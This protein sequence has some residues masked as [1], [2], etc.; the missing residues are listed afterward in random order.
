MK[1][2]ALPISLLAFLSLTATAQIDR[3]HAPAPGPAPEINIGTPAT[4]TLANGL[5]VFVV[6]NHKIPE[7]TAS[8]V[9]KTDPVLE[10][11]RT[12]YVNM[13]GA[14]MRRG[15][16]TKTKAQLDEEIDFLGGNVSTSSKGAS[17]SGLTKN[18]DK[19]FG[20]LADI[21]LHP[22]FPGSE[23]EKIRKQTLSGLEADKDDPG[24][25]SSNVAAVLNYGKDHPYGEVETEQTVKNI[26]LAD[27]KSYYDNYWKPN[28]GYLVLVG[29]IN[30]TAAERLVKKYFEGWQ[31]GEVPAHTYPVPQ[32]PAQT[33]VALVDRPAAVQSNVEITNPVVLKPGNPENIPAQL[34]NDVLGGGSDSYL[35][36]D[37]RE[38]HAY[39][40]GAYSGISNDPVVG[41]FDASAA[42]RNAVTDSAV[43]R[44]LYQLNNIRDNKVDPDV[45]E[46][47]KNSMSGS[48]ARSLES[49]GKI[50]QFALN[51][52][53]YNMPPDYY[54]DYLKNL[55]AVTAEDV[56]RAAR[57]FVTPEHTNIVIVGNAKEIAPGLAKFGEIKYFDNY[58][59]PVKAPE[60]KALP[61]GVT[62]TE[63]ISNYIKAIGG[64]EQLKAVKD[65]SMQATATIQG[66][67]VSFIQKVKYPDRY[68]KE[69]S[70]PKLNMIAMKQE[71]KGDSV[72]MQS[73]GQAV[74]IDEKTKKSI[75]E[76]MDLFPELK[77]NDP[78]YKMELT[79]IESVSGADAY[80]VKVT[81]PEGT[82][83]TY[84]FD[85]K[86]GYEVKTVRE[87]DGPAGKT[88]ATSELSDY[89]P[90][91][92]I[93]IPYALSLHQGQQNIALTVTEVKINSGLKE[94]DFK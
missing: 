39:T 37:L 45:L 11:D 80:V 70:I 73:R 12:G 27:V 59:N 71:V 15:T 26:A 72:S 8:L 67:E 20:I 33:F 74:P 5:K 56:Q 49:P 17:C 62:A 63:I 60:A 43:G 83:T 35:F 89:K 69:M 61:A 91:N 14:L 30:K 31:K 51:I 65:F 48:F 88:T 55:S 21:V 40:Y 4:F 50:A 6:E 53:L 86:T 47:F 44:L 28:I 78:G 94:D 42:V 10:K 84:Y 46:R 77:F 25:I 52:A 90:V 9:L 2:I 18:F 93:M 92:G 38:K 82:A 79:G 81:D 3:T 24:S 34:M 75:R 64:A 57:E 13:E 1:K 66:M 29:D 87:S 54:K 68:L 22:S 58:G 85:T 36:M 7:V 23:L 16:T 19:L 76:E 41:A 32:K